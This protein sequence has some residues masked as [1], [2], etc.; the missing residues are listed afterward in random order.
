MANVG[1]KESAAASAAGTDLMTQGNNSFFQFDSRP[2]IVSRIGVTGSSAVINAAVDLF[3][4]TEKIGTFYNT[5]SGA[6]AVQEARDLKPV[7]SNRA[8]MPHEPLR[9]IVNTPSAAT[10][11][12]VELEIQEV[13]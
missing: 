13:G 3:Y 12:Y 7:R 8:L 4:G 2:R 9:I 1:I 10:A 5:Q 11:L 6:A